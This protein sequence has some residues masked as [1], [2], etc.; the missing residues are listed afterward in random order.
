MP[1]DSDLQSGDV[2]FFE[3]STF[4]SDVK[5]RLAKLHGSIDWFNIRLRGGS[6]STDRYGLVLK[7]DAWHCKDEQGNHIT[8]LS[9]KPVFLVG[10][11]NKI[12]SYGFGIF[13]EMHYRFHQFLGSHDTI[14]MSGYGWNDSGINGRLIN[15]L[16]SSENKRLYLLH[17]EPENIRDES[18]SAMRHRY[19]E[20]VRCGRLIPVRKWLSEVGLEDLLQELNRP[21]PLSCVM[22]PRD[23]A[24]EVANLYR[25]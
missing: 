23:L 6:P 13:S 22:P 17:R 21:T 25:D 24:S 18:K 4:D 1:M 16:Y 19:D 10:T 11:Y 7:P 14:V 9:G 12:M 8:N 20:L 5:V 15:W 2:R 3:P